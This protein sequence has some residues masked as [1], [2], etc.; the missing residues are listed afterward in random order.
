M[1]DAG[2]TQEGWPYIVMELIEGTD[3]VTYAEQQK[4]EHGERI[5]LLIEVAH[6]VAFVGP[7][8]T[9]ALAGDDVRSRNWSGRQDLKLRP[10]DPQAKLLFRSR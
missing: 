9:L 1:Y 10:L 2:S 5:K 4:L 3:I 6:T 7:E 8:R